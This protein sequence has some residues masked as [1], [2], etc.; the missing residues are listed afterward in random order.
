M[1]TKT[2]NEA[3]EKSKMVRVVYRG[4]VQGRLERGNRGVEPV[5][6]RSSDL[7]EGGSVPDVGLVMTQ[8]RNVRRVMYD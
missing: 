4:R 8:S 5:G 3:V 2:P 1:L 7:T 6:S